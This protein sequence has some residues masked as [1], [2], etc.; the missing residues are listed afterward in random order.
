VLIERDD[1][2]GESACRSAKVQTS[3]IDFQLAAK[4]FFSYQCV[5]RWLQGFSAG[6]DLSVFCVGLAGFVI[7]DPNVSGRVALDEVDGAAE[8]NATVEVDRFGTGM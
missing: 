3:T 4:E 1:D 8:L 6:D 2:F 7:A 5:K